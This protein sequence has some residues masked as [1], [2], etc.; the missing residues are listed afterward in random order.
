MRSRRRV[1]ELASTPLLL[2]VLVA[3]VALLASLS[4]A[5]LEDRAINMLMTLILVVGL[6]VFAGNSGVFSFGHIGFMAIG[7][8]TA[9]MFRIP[10][11]T[12]AALFRSLPDV[13]LSSIEATLVGGA[14]AA[15]IATVVAIPLM[16]LSGLAASLGT[17]AFLNIVYVIASNWT[18]V[19]G[20]STG[21]A[22]VPQTTGR[23]S[24]LA[25]V[26]VIVLLA[27]AFQWTRACL[28]LRASREDEVAARAVGIGVFAQRTAAFVLSAF[29]TGIAGA[30]FAQYY[31]SFNPSS[32]F[33]STTFTTVAMLVVGGRLSLSGA[34]VGTLFISVVTELLRRIEMGVDLGVFSIPARPGLQDVGVALTMLGVLLLRR[35]GLTG[36]RELGPPGRLPGIRGGRHSRGPVAARG[37]TGQP[38]GAA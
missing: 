19:S 1:R 18:S 27:W 17:F 13:Q 7:A 28:R 11:E 33:V 20:G 16:R 6:Y 14:A 30:L 22:N 29:I 8:Y 9:A 36:N 37:G 25:W 32:F 12:K 26:A 38:R 23:Y 31:G 24:T 34:V 35:S 4:S 15:V 21:L 10:A 3:A 5:I 2:I